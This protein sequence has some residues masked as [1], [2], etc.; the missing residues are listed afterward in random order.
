MFLRFGGDGRS[1]G[2]KRREEEEEEA[3]KSIIR[4]LLPLVSRHRCRSCMPGIV[5]LCSPSLSRCRTISPLGQLIPP[6]PSLMAI[7][8][9]LQ[10]LQKWVIG[11]ENCTLRLLLVALCEFTQPL[12][13]LRKVGSKRLHELAYRNQTEPW[14]GILAT[15]KQSCS[16]S[17]YGPDRYKSR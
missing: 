13:P 2:G 6:C 3:R 12:E 4:S 11:C 14:V 16:Q 15:Y 10:Y 9:P 5:H 7:F 17:P 1:D 8:L